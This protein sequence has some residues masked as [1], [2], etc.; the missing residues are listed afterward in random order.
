M[1]ET[2]AQ[3]SGIFEDPNGD[4]RYVTTARWTNFVQ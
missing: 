4:L 1:F 3:F 2:R